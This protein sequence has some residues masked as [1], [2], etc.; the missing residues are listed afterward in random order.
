MDYVSNHDTIV[1]PTSHELKRVSPPKVEAPREKMKLV[2]KKTNGLKPKE[3]SVTKR[4]EEPAKKPKEDATKSPKS[5]IKPLEKSKPSTP[6]NDTSPFESNSKRRKVS[7]LPEVESIEWVTMD[8]TKLP[9]VSTIKTDD[10]WIKVFDIYKKYYPTYRSIYAQ[11]VKNKFQFETLHLKMKKASASE[12]KEYENLIERLLKERSQRVKDMKKQ[13]S[14]LHEKMSHIKTCID[15]Y[16][17][18]KSQVS[19]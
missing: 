15:T 10:D 18:K 7:K 1:Q 4:L 17:E 8:T 12:K 3:E 9:K 2:T 11:L 14:D 6:Q 5:P 16:L 13:Y 19:K